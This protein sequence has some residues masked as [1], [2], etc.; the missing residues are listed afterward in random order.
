MND[1]VGPARSVCLIGCGPRGASIVERILANVPALYGDRP[2]DLHI[3]DPYPPGAAVPGAPT[4]P[5]CCG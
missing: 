4:S 2:L 1:P 3:V 5:V